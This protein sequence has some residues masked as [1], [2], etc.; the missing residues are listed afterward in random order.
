MPLSN[1]APASSAVVPQW[2]ALPAFG[3]RADDR[4]ESDWFSADVKCHE[5]ALRAYLRKRFPSL[6]D[7]DDVVQESYTRLLRVRASGRPLFAKA[8]LFTA[9]RNVA[10]DMFRRRAVVPHE[11]LSESDGELP[12]LEETPGVADALDRQERHEL[13]L[14][15]VGALPERCRQV[16]LLRHRDGLSYKDIAIRLG[17]APGTVKLHMVKGVRDCI[18]FFREHGMLDDDAGAMGEPGGLL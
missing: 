6:S 4:R 14:E 17:I 18:A 11:S 12:V 7:H 2:A 1:P 15:A 3:E 8:F 10:I 13:L 9:A 16:M 5:P